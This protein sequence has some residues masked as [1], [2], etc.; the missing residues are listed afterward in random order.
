MSLEEARTVDLYSALLTLPKNLDVEHNAMND[1][2]NSEIPV[3]KNGRQLSS[4][5][6]GR[7]KSKKAMLAR[8]AVMEGKRE[9][10]ETPNDERG[11]KRV[12][13]DE[14]QSVSEEPS[15]LT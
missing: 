3:D 1:E 10:S 15:S 6:I 11:T 8:S 2:L 13:A 4:K 9:S 14:V 5:E 7:L 12:K